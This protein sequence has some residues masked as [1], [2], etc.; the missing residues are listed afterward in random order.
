M[1][2]DNIRRPIPGDHYFYEVTMKYYAALFHI[3]MLKEST[4]YFLFLNLNLLD[5]DCIMD[6]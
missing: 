5:L 2:K 1:S 3:C 6:F 4:Y